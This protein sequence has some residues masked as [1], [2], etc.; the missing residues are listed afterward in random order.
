MPRSLLT[1]ADRPGF[2]KQPPARAGAMRLPSSW[3][4]AGACTRMPAH[5]LWRNGEL[6]DCALAAAQIVPMERS[7]ATSCGPHELDVAEP[8]VFA[9]ANLDG[10]VQFA[11][12]VGDEI[13]RGARW[14][15]S[16]HVIDAGDV[17]E[18]RG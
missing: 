12:V 11:A 9:V 17:R 18:R 14:N 16:E 8:V 3:R 2:A 13:P 4:G 10:H 6:S 5:L 15:R 1:T 7:G